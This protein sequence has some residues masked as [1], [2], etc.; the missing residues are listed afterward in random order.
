V[1]YATPHERSHTNSSARR[2]GG[3]DE[4]RGWHSGTAVTSAQLSPDE[5]FLD[6][7]LAGGVLAVAAL[8]QDR[9]RRVASRAET[10][11][12]SNTEKELKQHATTTIITVADAGV[13]PTRGAHCMVGLG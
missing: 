12:T 13:R 1:Q 7:E 8:G 5:A 6:K 11:A 9:C 3:D 4:V 2:K 10:N